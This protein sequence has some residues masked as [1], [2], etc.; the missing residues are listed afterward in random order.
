MSQFDPK[1]YI[2]MIQKTTDVKTDDE[3][4]YFDR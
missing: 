4:F 3:Y 1:S 2:R